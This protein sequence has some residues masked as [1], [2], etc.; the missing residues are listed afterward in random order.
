MP[1]PDWKD[2][3]S[4]IQQQDNEV[5]TPG[6]QEMDPSYAQ[7]Y[8][9][10]LQNEAISNQVMQPQS[11]ASA[12][13]SAKVLENAP[14]TD[15]DVQ[16]ALANA[17]EPAANPRF[18]AEPASAASGDAKLDAL[19]KDANTPAHR[20]LTPEEISAS[21]ED[22]TK[23]L[24]AAEEATE[25]MTNP[26][27]LD[28]ALEP[29]VDKAKALAPEAEEGFWKKVA[30]K[31]PDLFKEL[32]G[33]E[34][35]ASAA[36]V[37]SAARAG[38]NTAKEVAG[39]ALGTAGEI[40]ASPAGQLAGKAIGGAATAAQLLEAPT[41]EA[42]PNNAF[43]K[44]ADEIPGA[45]PGK[46]GSP[47]IYGPPATPEN[48]AGG[49]ATPPPATAPA[50][51]AK[52][53]DEEEETPVA[54]AKAAVNSGKSPASIAAAA[55]PAGAPATMDPR[56]AALIAAQQAQAQAATNNAIGRAGNDLGAALGSRH[57]FQ[58]LKANNSA[59]DEMDKQAA[60]NVQNQKDLA[61]QAQLR[62]ETDLQKETL[63]NAQTKND[64]NSDVSALS[65]AIAKKS[66]AAIG[67]NPNIITDTTS[68]ASIEKI[69]PG[70]EHM[71]A[72][73]NAA[74]ARKLV[75]AQ[76]TQDNGDKQNE[77]QMQKWRTMNDFQTAR[78]STTAGAAYNRI[79]NADALDNLLDAGANG[80]LS[81]EQVHEMAT[82]QSRLAAGGAASQSGTAGFNQGTLKGMGS[83]AYE[84]V[85]GLPGNAITP[86][87]IAMNRQSA[88]AERKAG[89][90]TLVQSL[91]DN[92]QSKLLTD[93]RSGVKN[94]S[95][96]RQKLAGLGVSGPG[97][98]YI[99]NSIKSG[100]KITPADTKKLFPKPEQAAKPAAAATQ[101][102]PAD[103]VK[104][105]NPNGQTGM[106]PKAQLAAALQQGYTEVQ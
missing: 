32:L 63:K 54:A 62:T 89:Q 25:T 102:A 80:K 65:R 18:A 83:K 90:A 28:K 42:M 86:E 17:N 94:E 31:A 58:P 99:V 30:R 4:K 19:L 52:D 26:N 98:E 74:E 71:A 46:D 49:P 96:V 60:Q 35:G 106:I 56:E 48:M 73:Y 10:A 21:G 103:K 41:N 6:P 16:E 13:D 39:K 68:A 47:Q 34:A 22:V 66:L 85:T 77:A 44:N 64:P 93:P 59:Y 33:D 27:V 9:P 50:I 40:A 70:I 88:D 104:V 97:I 87:M 8:E 55:K 105:K 61:S 67:G 11:G 12:A 78:S 84:F 69:M 38:I 76:K 24:P 79:A 14:I 101:N 72:N 37:N 57:T 23:T 75:L 7:A 1:T 15:A 82:I 3:L 36:E 45:I 100:N 81:N 51:A 95:E 53:E 91:A 5:A 20:Q 2:L 43:Q 92:T 29:V